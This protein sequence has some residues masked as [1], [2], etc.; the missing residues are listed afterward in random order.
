MPR[1]RVPLLLRAVRMVAEELL[2]ELEPPI[3]CR[4]LVL[5]PPVGCKTAN[6]P[7]ECS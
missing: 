2:L 6:F 3:G 5:H 4:A 1:S 7:K